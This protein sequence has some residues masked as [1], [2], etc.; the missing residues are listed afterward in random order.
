[1]NFENIK[2]EDKEIY[3]LIEKELDRQRK[4]IE[5]I[6]SE[7]VVS[8]AVMEA[9]G[10]Y[11]TNKY[12]E[13]YPGKRYYGGCH[14]VDEIEQIAIDRAKQLFG[15]EHANVQPHSGSQANMAVYFTVLEPGDTVLGMD[16]SHGGHLTHG[17]PVNFSGKLFK[18]VSY[19][20]DKETEMIDYGNVRQI[21]LECKP[22]L[23]VAGASAYSRTIDFAKFR[24]IADEVGAY[25]MVDMAH[26]AGL[27]AAGVHPSPVPYCDF[28]TTTTHKTLRGPRGGLILCK[29][30]Y[31]KDLNK[32][33]FPGIQGGPLEHIIAAKAVCFKE[34]LDPKFKEYAENVVE[35]CIELAEQLIKR[36]FKIVSGGTD[37]HVFLVDLNNKDI[38]GKEAEQLL[39]SVGITANK[40]TVPNETRSPFVTSGIRIGTAAITT[41]GFVKEDMA[42]IAAIMDEAIANREGDLSGLKA[43]VEA[44]CD[45]HPLY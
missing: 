7:N 22:K 3:D 40:N 39:D 11:L 14:V 32:N 9:M 8:E 6:A 24:E 10:S 42:E 31:A 45:K 34:A 5:L 25:L 15:A 17:S 16:L 4:G 26:I 44:L 23:I 1:M 33:I 28:V 35:N 37:N 2:R 20:V 21:A 36:D 30:K 12:A 19:G 41:R 29:E 13:G 18:F 43:R 38:T 27:V